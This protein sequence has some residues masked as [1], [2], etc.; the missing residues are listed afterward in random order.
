MQLLYFIST[1]NN[2]YKNQKD[3]L[4]SLEK[5]KDKL[6]FIKIKDMNNI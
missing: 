4:K 3:K 5:Y 2:Y 1:V 6:V